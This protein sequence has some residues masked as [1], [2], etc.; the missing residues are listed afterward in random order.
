[1]EKNFNKKTWV[2]LS[3]FLP[4][5]I[6]IGFFI[7][8]ESLSESAR[9]SKEFNLKIES[10]LESGVKS[11]KLSDITDFEWDVVCFYNEEGG[12]I[13]LKNPELIKQI[14]YKPKL[15]I[16]SSYYIPYDF[17]G[18]L[19]SDSKTKKIRVLHR[20]RMWQQTSKLQTYYYGGCYS[21]ENLLFL[22]TKK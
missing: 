19:F 18:L 22:L 16:R 14:G 4:L 15:L 5:I 12:S 6:W 2:I 17:S 13:N 7:Y 11:F 21:D 20:L 8:D 9:L 1:M 3:L 10:T